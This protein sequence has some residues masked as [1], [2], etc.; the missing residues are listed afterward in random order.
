MFGQVVR[1]LTAGDGLLQRIMDEYSY[2]IWSDRINLV[3]DLTD[4]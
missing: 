3:A 2:Y 1:R 4:F